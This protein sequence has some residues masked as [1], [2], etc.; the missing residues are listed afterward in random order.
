M[1]EGCDKVY[2][3][4]NGGEHAIPPAPAVDDSVFGEDFEDTTGT[5]ALLMRAASRCLEL[6]LLA[7]DPLS[8]VAGR[9]ASG[10]ECRAHMRIASALRCFWKFHG[11]R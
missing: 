11:A 1:E 5:G 6:E 4:Q 10:A 9:P 2:L 8:G 7:A 3:S